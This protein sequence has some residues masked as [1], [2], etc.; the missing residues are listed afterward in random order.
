MT[1]DLLDKFNRIMGTALCSIGIYVL[2]LACLGR[3]ASCGSKKVNNE[4]IERIVAKERIALSIP[5]NISIETKFADQITNVRKLSDKR[6]VINLSKK[7][8][9]STIKHELY[10]IADGHCDSLL[11]D[12]RAGHNGAY[13]MAKYLFW[14]EPQ[15]VLYEA[16]GLR[17]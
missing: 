5:N 14:H 3:C 12:N 13:I 15:A 8:R 4:N 2:G 1:T 9:Q 6:Y 10:H 17:L 7:C 16:F 11:E